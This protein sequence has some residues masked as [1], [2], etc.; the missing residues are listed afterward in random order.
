VFQRLRR[1]I[2]ASFDA[3][4]D[5]EAPHAV[6]VVVA[7]RFLASIQIQI[8]SNQ[9]K[10]IRETTT[11]TRRRDATSDE[12]RARSTRCRGCA[13]RRAGVARRDARASSRRDVRRRGARV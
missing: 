11:T 4:V 10:S 13:T 1:D 9:I 3:R 8:K 6:V 7:L 12:R 2:A 5:V